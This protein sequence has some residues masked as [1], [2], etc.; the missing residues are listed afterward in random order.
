MLGMNKK[1]SPAIQAVMSEE[2]RAYVIFLAKKDR[3]SVSSYVKLALEERIKNLSESE[4]RRAIEE[5]ETEYSA[6]AD[7]K[8]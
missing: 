4:K 2:E 3:R 7:S 8:N 1:Q 6:T 5:Y